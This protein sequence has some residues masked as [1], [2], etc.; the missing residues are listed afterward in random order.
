MTDGES[1]AWDLWRRNLMVWA[2]LLAL[3]TL[4]FCAAYLP[5]GSFNA[6]VALSIAALKVGLVA[7]FFMELSSSDPLLRLAA[8]AGLFWLAILFLL[9]FNDYLTRPPIVT[10]P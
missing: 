6:P 4:T 3:L 5:L 2:A 10:G 8:G 7:L 9:A 1:C